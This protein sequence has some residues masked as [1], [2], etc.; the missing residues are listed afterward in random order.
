M[1]YMYLS[2]YIYIFIYV[3]VFI[4]MHMYV[5]MYCVLIGADIIDGKTAMQMS[6]GTTRIFAMPFDSGR[7]MWQLSFPMDEDVAI[8]LTKK[9]PAALKKEALTRCGTWATPVP[10]LLAAAD[11]GLISGWPYEPNAWQHERNSSSAWNSE[12]TV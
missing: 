10:E 8:E 4:N 5:Y 7:V 6:D 3:Y 12:Q 1:Y 9:G 11:I 2:I